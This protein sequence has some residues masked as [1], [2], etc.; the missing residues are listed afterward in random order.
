MVE[1]GDWLV[2]RY[3][4]EPFYDKPALT[5]W[6]IGASFEVF[7]TDAGAGRL[8][9]AL[10][11]VGVLLAASWLGRQLFDASVGSTAAWMLIT[12]PALVAFGRTAM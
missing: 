1:T 11:L 7:G 8:P 2:P 12:T 4:G 10:A 3:R 6:S 9:S 5:Y